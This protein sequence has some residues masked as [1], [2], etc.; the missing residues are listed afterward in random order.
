MFNR[1]LTIKD[2][3]YKETKK[4]C[5]HFTL[6]DPEKQ[7]DIE[8]KAKRLQEL[9]TDAVMVGGSASMNHIARLALNVLGIKNAKKLAHVVGVRHVSNIK[10][11]DSA[12]LAIKKNSKLPVILFPGGVGGISKHAD[13]IF[14][15]SLMN[16]KDVYWVSGAQSQGS[17]IVKQYGIEPISMAYLIVEPGMRVGKIGKADLIKRS[18]PQVAAHYALAA[19]YMGMS[20]IYLEAGSGAPEPVPAEMIRQVKAMTKIPLI[21]GGGIRKPEQALACMKAG[22]DIIVTGTITEENFSALGEIIKCVKNYKK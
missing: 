12:V 2:F 6:I 17:F 22:A 5:L 14:F 4:R 15:M 20:L 7:Q 8:W 13:A 1:K 10:T 9:G 16:S 18:A 21:V 19:Q 11:L 3:I